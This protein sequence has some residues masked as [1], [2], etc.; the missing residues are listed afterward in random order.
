MSLFCLFS[1]VSLGKIWL[2]HFHVVASQNVSSF[3]LS[4]KD[5]RL[6]LRSRGL[7]AKPVGR[8]R[9]FVVCMELIL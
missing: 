2:L 7:S 1:P 9:K 6:I 5:C 3:R 4:V 8:P